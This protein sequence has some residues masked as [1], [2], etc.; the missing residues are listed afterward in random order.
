MTAYFEYKG[1]SS[2]DMHLRIL[3]EISFPSPEADIEFVEIMGKDGEL[4]IDNE[5]LKGV[6]FPIPVVLK[7]P[8]DKT[9]E[10][11]ATEISNWLKNDIGWYPLR[12]SG[13]PNYEYIAMCYEQFNIEETLRQFGKT[14][15]TFRLKP[16][17]RFRDDK[18]IILS[19]GQTIVNKGTRVAK[20]LIRIE[21]HGDITLTNN[22]KDWLMLTGVDGHITVD[23]ESMNVYRSNVVQFTKMKAHLKPLFPVLNIGNNKIEWTGNVTKI[24]LTPRTEVVF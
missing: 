13:S 19:N 20:P 16:Y 23:S 14:V 5:R 2:L 11:T 21:G 8:N 17:K 18:S 3:N 22:G 6:N 24:E 10:E 1:I 9:V 7:T 12:F 4:A 15:I